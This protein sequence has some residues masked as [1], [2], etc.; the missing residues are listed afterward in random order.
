MNVWPQL[1]GRMEG[2]LVVVEPLVPEHEEDLFAAGLDQEMWRYLTSF[3]GAY[4]TRERFHRWMEEALA[5]SA[6]GIEGA[7]AIVDR[8]SGQAIG[9]TRYMALRPEHHSLEIGWTWLGR[10]WWRTGVNV[11][12]KLLLLR[13]A[14][15]QLGCERVELKTD[16]RNARS[17]A[18]MEALPAHFEGVHRRHRKIPSGWRDTAWYSVIAPEW[19]HVRAA[20]HERLGR[21]GVA[22]YAPGPR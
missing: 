16:A 20:L 4:E 12:T 3:P 19:P 14:F 18:A 13:R 5:A 6:A 7:W 11:E 9:S 8:P 15:E 22:G 17:R 2:E 21:H 10:P 1:T